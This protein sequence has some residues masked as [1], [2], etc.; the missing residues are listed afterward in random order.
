M[1]VEMV[2]IESG[3]NTADNIFPLVTS[4]INGSVTVGANS[5]VMLRDI[6]NGYAVAN[7]TG[8]LLLGADRPFAVTARAYSNRYPLGQTIPAASRFFENSF[9]T[10]DNNAVVYVPGIMSNASTR[11]NIGF[12]AGAGSAAAMVVEV[13]LRNAT[14]GVAGTR[15]FFIPSGSF[16]HMQ[17]SARSFANAN[18]DVG[19]VEFRVIEGSGTIVPYASLV[20]NNTGEATYIMG[21]FP[22]STGPTMS[23]VP[24]LFRLLLQRNSIR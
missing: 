18:V 11:T 8:A 7:I 21:Q 4:S 17:F 10:A 22:D 6:L 19:T 12:V 2:L 13:T 5:T 24:S 23:S 1:T 14:G 20:D 16:A 9:G 15:T 3:D